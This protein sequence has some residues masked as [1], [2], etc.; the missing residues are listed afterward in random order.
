M[1][2]AM[3]ELALYALEPGTGVDPET[4]LRTAE[5]D[6]AVNLIPF[7]LRRGSTLRPKTEG[8][9]IKVYFYRPE[10]PGELIHTYAYQPEANWT[11]YSP[12][13]SA[14][15]WT[16]GEYTAP[17][18]G[19]VRV[20]VAGA[21]PGEAPEEGAALQD[22]VLTGE[23]SCGELPVPE[24]MTRCEESLK[25]RVTACR[26]E[27]DLLLF[28]L[29]DTHYT[30]GCI[31]PDTLR[32]LRLAA[33]ELHPDAVVHLGDFTDGLLPT[34]YTRSIAAM[35]LA[36][37]RTVCGRLWCCVGNHDRNYFRGNPG[38]MSREECARLYLDR[39]TPW[40]HVDFP[41]QKLRLLFLDSFDPTEKERYGFPP[42]EVRWLR[43][44]LLTT[45]R[46]YRV[47]VFSHVPPA[48][49][50]HVWSETIRNEERMFRLLE[51]FHARRG[52]SVLGWVHGHSHADQIYEKRAFPVIGIGCAKLE[53]FPEH[54]PEGSVTYPR[55]QHSQ[56]QE[57]WDAL[58]IHAE[59]GSLDFLRFGAG[60][61]RH[62]EMKREK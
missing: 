17:A 47:L 30:A 36:D 42:E 38:A 50:I 13:L 59:T 22:R 58:L 62:V 27:K 1:G 15:E 40:Y 24:W 45:P 21:V 12:E 41:A 14:L 54:K 53:D 10:V 4:G 39:E 33:E 55:E 20:A 49:E 60:E 23:A 29:A 37:L 35:V 6:C 5:A 2:G 26:R 18:D 32:S 56:N 43:R 9:R 44:R 7:P 34:A 31:W 61:D 19:F 51:R 3:K 57:L 8:D 16:D 11:T 46:A 48:A 52:G 28:L 25:Q